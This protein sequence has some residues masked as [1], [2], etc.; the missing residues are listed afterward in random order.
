MTDLQVQFEQN[1]LL[2]MQFSF[3]FNIES[4]R[5][6]GFGTNFFFQGNMLLL[7]LLLLLLRG[8]NSEFFSKVS[9]LFLNSSLT[10]YRV[11]IKNLNNITLKPLQEDL[12][13]FSFTY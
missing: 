3:F 1:F 11:I 2:Q 6:I 4:E 10:T 13:F 7:L 8:D 12:I 9:V 5:V